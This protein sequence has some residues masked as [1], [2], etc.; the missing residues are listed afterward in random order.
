MT[1]GTTPPFPGSRMERRRAAE[2]AKAAAA[3]KAQDPGSDGPEAAKTS[4]DEASISEP[5][6][7]TTAEPA[8]PE[9]NEAENS[10][11]SHA[12]EPE[13]K[14]VDAPES[15]DE[16]SHPQGAAPGV[17]GSR[18][19]VRKKSPKWAWVAIGL[20]AV[21]II[22]AIILAIFAFTG[23]NN[24]NSQS[25]EQQSSNTVTVPASGKELSTLR[26][27]CA[28]GDMMACDQLYFEAPLGS[29]DEA[30]GNTCGE[31]QLPGKYCHLSALETEQS[32]SPQSENGEESAPQS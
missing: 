18:V 12:P 10:A 3:E 7:E 8:H 17:P 11:D 16:A 26:E 19:S 31:R 28:A 2:A 29:E 1:D 32:S 22:A 4:T 13:P 21:L 20:G 14:D 30:F 24:N 25:G 23:S 9:G 15:A 6:T 5:G 27:E